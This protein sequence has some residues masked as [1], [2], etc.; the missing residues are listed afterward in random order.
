MSISQI[1]SLQNTLNSALDA[2]KAELA[3]QGLS[4][5]TLDTSKLHEIDDITYL[6][7]PA[8]YEARRAALA[9]LVRFYL[10]LWRQKF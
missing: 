9:C 4:E 10:T 1:T 3:S 6:P 2:F 5:P 7:S 8:M